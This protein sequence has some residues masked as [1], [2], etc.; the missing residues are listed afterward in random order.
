MKLL[1][2]ELKKIIF[3]KRFFYLI[4]IM[5]AGIVVLFVRNIM[6]ESYVEKEAVGEV[7]S[8][9]ESSQANKRILNNSL[10]QDPD[11]KEFKNLQAI[12]DRMLPALYEWENAVSSDDWQSKIKLE[13]AF[14]AIVEEYRNAG[15]DHPISFSEIEQTTALNQKLLNENIKPE[16]D[17]FSTALPNFLKV[18]VDL[19][20]NLGAIIIVI[21]FFGDLM[22]S[23]YE[24]HSIH[25]L[26]TQPL[27]K[28]HI[29]TTKFIVTLIG[30]AFL[31]CLLL[32]TAGVA[33]VI[34]GEKGTFAYPV[35][36][37]KNNALQ[38]ITIQEYIV[39]GIIITSVIILVVVALALLLG[40]LFKHTLATVL[41]LAG[42]LLASYMMTFIAWDPLYWIN[43]F[44]Y[45]LA[46]K[47]ILEQD[48]KVWYQGIPAAVLLAVMCYII[49]IRKIKTSKIG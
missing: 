20:I 45:V 21:L 10:E 40:L 16:H 42:L 36:I 41:V 11:N 17:A 30:Y 3:N 37:E 12:N 38:F 44:Q 5:V 2:F 39:Q 31:L 23:E 27:N 1:S 34:F 13:N 4:L 7:T 8:F 49:S 15:G 6:F 18:V 28:I 24:H 25:L 47:M 48:G 35:L 22:S 26:L 14:L 33:G 46:Q 29:V 19:F 43:P 32:A 9:I